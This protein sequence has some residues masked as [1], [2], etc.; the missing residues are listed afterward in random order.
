MKDI[1]LFLDSGAFSAFTKGVH[2]DIQ[3]YIKFIKDN[4][5]YID[6]Y[7]NLDVIG[8]AEAT[9]KNQRIME[10]AGLKPLPCFHYG[11]DI[12]YL[13]TYLQEHDYI[14]LGGMV[15]ISTNDL[16][17][18][19][20]NL[21]SN[22]LCDKKGYP[23]VKVHGFGLTSLKLLRR[24]PWYCM[25]EE[26]HSVLTKHGWF[27]L[28]NLSVGDEI[29]AFDNGRT[30][31]QKI[32]EV[33]I[34][35]VVDVD[36]NRLF[37]RNFEAMVSGNHRWCVSNINHRDIN[38]Q[39]R[40]TDTLLAGDCINRVGKYSFPEQKIYTD[41]Q[42][43]ALAWFW[44]DGS[45]KHR[46]KYNT[47]SVIIYQSEKANPE[48]CFMIR[49]L[50]TRI[51]EPFCE[52]KAKRDLVISFELYGA[53]ANWLLSIAP[54]KKLPND[55]PFKMT[56]NQSKDFI[57]YSILADGFKTQLKRSEGIAITATKQIKQENFE[58]VRIIC[59]LLGIPTSVFCNTDGSK[60]L[61]S[62]S[63]NHI[64]V[65]KLKKETIKYTGRLWCVRVPSGAFFT[66]CKDKIYVTGNSVD[67][68]SWVMASRMGTIYIP[69]RKSGKWIY[70]KD[71]WKVAISSQSP[72]KSDAGMHFE[73]FSDA[74]QKEILL[75][76][77]EKGY[78]LGKSEFHMESAKY[79]LKEGERW[80]GK[81]SS[82][83]RLV[84]TIIEKGVCNHYKDRDEINIIYYIDLEKS[85]PE[86][87]YKFKS[88][89]N[90]FG[91]C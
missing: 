10:D 9:L 74:Q 3:E 79:E 86:W 20:D 13:H 15:P 90:C 59:L 2:I 64:Y 67:S 6:V 34:F 19:L 30:E 84:E 17:H 33:S 43:Q 53:L 68:T 45:I 56:E 87:P 4:E 85:F 48:K 26:D 49:D 8:D 69:Q 46:P 32:Q 61:L 42:I 47:D 89:R 73:T 63:V 14:A 66:K 57:K 62:S 16:A 1:S 27:N 70:D 54:N 21:F 65:N 91:F 41:D 60:S 78:R 39:W 36:I 7:A 52:S 31:W 88:K 80:G 75:Y 83:K 5:R 51:K 22:F 25:T 40:T 77:D 11:D 58:I 29:L 81:E 28:S 38:Y 12:F 76:L 18:W 55:L 50:L 44:T 23:I 37:N 72:K 35:D 71:P 82:G 24:Y